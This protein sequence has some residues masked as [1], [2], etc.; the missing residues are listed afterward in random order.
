MR[1]R[2]VTS[3][4]KSPTPFACGHFG[5]AVESRSSI[6][7][8]QAPAAFGA[9]ITFC[10]HLTKRGAAP[11]AIQ[12]LGGHRD[13]GTTQRSMHLS[14]AAVEGAIRLLDQTAP[15]FGRGNIVATAVPAGANANI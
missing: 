6:R 11:R 10:S 2:C 15:V 7:F 12:E 8:W 9:V 1:P 3:A 14:P 5:D 4:A 13:L